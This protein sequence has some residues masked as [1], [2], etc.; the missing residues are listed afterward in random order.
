MT[1]Q[2]QS[3]KIPFFIA[4]DENLIEQV[5]IYNVTQRDTERVDN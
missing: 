5:R 3:R 4:D 2:T 1:E